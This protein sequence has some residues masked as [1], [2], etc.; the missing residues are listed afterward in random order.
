MNASEEDRLPE[1]QLLGQMSYVY[2]DA[3]KVLQ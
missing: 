3:E 2:F 1:D